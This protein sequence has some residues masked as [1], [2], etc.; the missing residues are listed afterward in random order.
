MQ[1][2]NERRKRIKAKIKKEEARNENCRFY[3][4]LF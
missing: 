1:R 3:P 2:L 4:G